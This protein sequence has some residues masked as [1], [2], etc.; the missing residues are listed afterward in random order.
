MKKIIFVSILSLSFF[1]SK[2]QDNKP[3]ANSF[4]MQYG[5]NFNGGVSQAVQFSGWLKHGLE[6]RGAMT[7]NYSDNST[8]SY[9]GSNYM[10]VRINNTYSYIP[11]ITTSSST[12]ASLTVTPI[13]SVV[14]HF[15]TKN[16]L[17]FFVGGAFNYGFSIPTA[18]STNSSST[19]ADSFYSY[20][21]TSSKGPVTFNWGLSLI[22]GTNFFFYKNL[23]LG[24]DLGIGFTA[25][26][27]SGTYQEHDIR[28]SN[29]AYG[30]NVMNINQTINTKQTNNRYTASL[31][32]NAG[33]HLTYYLKV[34]K[35]KPA[36]TSKI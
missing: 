7:F 13:I 8:S 12:S 21:S 26:N 28:T 33:L 2:A 23:A 16:N 32:G 27:S 30:T 14:K 9:N 17:D 15:P 36:A 10:Q 34:N 4:G 25:S 31:T 5:V 19:T 35:H 6:V 11:T 18:W 1:L 29:G 20:N 3:E 24:A 22:G